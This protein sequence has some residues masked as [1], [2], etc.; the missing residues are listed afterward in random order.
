VLLGYFDNAPENDCGNCDVCREPPEQF[1]ATEEARKAL[2]CVYRVGQ[3]FGMGHVIDVL[4]G[5]Q[6]QRIRSLGH[7]KLSTY[8]IGRDV[9]ADGWGSIIRQLVHLGYLEQDLTA[10]SVLRLTRKAGPLLRGEEALSLARPRVRPLAVKKPART[11][12]SGSNYDENLFQAL[13]SLR[14]KLADAAGMPPFVVF[15]DATL[16]EMALNQPVNAEELLRINGVGMHK[17][18]RYGAEFIA[19]IRQHRSL[20]PDYPASQP[21]L[22]PDR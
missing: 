10:Y 7:D 14:K 5:S 8:G 16:A 9:S 22:E 17:L 6:N 19:V 1:D 3:R 15:G 18:G 4:R 21:Q 20:A 12:I 2:S 11:T 13:R